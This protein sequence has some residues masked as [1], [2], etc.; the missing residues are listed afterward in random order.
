MPAAPPKKIGVATSSN[1]NVPVKGS[2]SGNGLQFIFASPLQE[3][4]QRK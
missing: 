1:K 3:P 4:D 2:S